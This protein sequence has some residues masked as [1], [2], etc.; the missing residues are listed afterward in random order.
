MPVSSATSWWLK[1]QCSFVALIHLNVCCHWNSYSLSLSFSHM[2]HLFLFVSLCFLIRILFFSSTLF[3]N[4]VQPEYV[5]TWSS[6]IHNLPYCYL[7]ILFYFSYITLSSLSLLI[8]SISILLPSITLIILFIFLS[9]H[10][11]RWGT[12][13]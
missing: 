11:N 8:Y 5:L 1:H 7:T 6:F 13:W 9:L 3:T 10:F 2:H 12:F 4:L